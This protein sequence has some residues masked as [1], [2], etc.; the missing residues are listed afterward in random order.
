M[1]SSSAW[2]TDQELKLRTC[3]RRQLFALD[4]AEGWSPGQLNIELYNL[5]MTPASNLEALNIALCQRVKE[6]KE[7]GAA[8]GGCP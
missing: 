3:I 6:A 7:S 8:T 1:D 2:R 5:R 4:H